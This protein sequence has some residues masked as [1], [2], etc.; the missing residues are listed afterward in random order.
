ML[1]QAAEAIVRDKLGLGPGVDLAE[2]S[3]RNH[4]REQLGRQPRHGDLFALL[5]SIRGEISCG[6]ITIE[7]T[8]LL[9]TAADIA[10][11]LVRLEA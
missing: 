10:R 5:G 2:V 9:L 11:Y 7:E 8:E 3:V 4:L 1:L 6:G